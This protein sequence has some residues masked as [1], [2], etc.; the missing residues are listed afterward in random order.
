MTNLENI[1]LNELNLPQKVKHLQEVV[2]VAKFM[3]TGRMVAGRDREKDKAS[4]LQLQG[5]ESLETSS[6]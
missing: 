4:E 5:M 3:K 6:A 2:R 1:M